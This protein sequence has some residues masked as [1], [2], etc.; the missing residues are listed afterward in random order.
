MRDER[1]ERRHDVGFSTSVASVAFQGQLAPSGQSPQMSG[2]AGVAVSRRKKPLSHASQLAEP[3]PLDVRCRQRV[4]AERPSSGA[5]KPRS[6]GR[7]AACPAVLEW[8][9]GTQR[10]QLT[11]PLA[12]WALP[13]EHGHGT[14]YVAPED[15]QRRW[16][17]MDP[18]N[19]FNPGVG[20]LSVLR[21]YGK[22][23]AAAAGKSGSGGP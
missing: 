7:H 10:S 4:Q 18:L 23:E 5:W 12:G 16:M 3:L 6:H 20:G 13:A 8:V 15:T 2:V 21:R 14:E 9:P 17:E 22:P 19:V 11:L 1:G